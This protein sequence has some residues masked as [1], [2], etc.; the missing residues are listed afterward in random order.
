VLAALTVIPA[1][2]SSDGKAQGVRRG[3]P[4][5]WT[6]VDLAAGDQPVRLMPMGDRLLVGVRHPG[7]RTVPRLLV[8]SADGM[9]T[10]V[11]L[12]PKT[13]YA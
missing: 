10:P 4:L 7:A 9:L 11:P 1:C 13:P 5:T 12:T 8:R 2:S 3:E 6:K